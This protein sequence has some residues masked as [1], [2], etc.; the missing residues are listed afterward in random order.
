MS[1]NSWY[2]LQYK[3]SPKFHVHRCFT[4]R[5]SQCDKIQ[6]CNWDLTE[7]LICYDSVGLMKPIKFCSHPCL[8]EVWLTF[9]PFFCA[10]KVKWSMKRNPQVYELTAITVQ[11]GFEQSVVQKPVSSSVVCLS[12]L[13]WGS[14]DRKTQSPKLDCKAVK[15]DALWIMSFW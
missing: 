8:S 5:A 13:L 15:S 7:N 12:S 6:L 11:G 10:T 2:V 9:I 3:N 14:K 4:S 1:L